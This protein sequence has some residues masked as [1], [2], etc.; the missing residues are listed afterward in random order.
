MLQQ[1]MH[2]V[3]DEIGR[4]F[5]AGIEQENAVV[6][7]LGL[8]EALCPIG[9]ASELAPS[10]ERRQDLPLVVRLVPRA[11]GDEVFQVIL[12]LG[13]RPRAALEL[14]FGKNGLRTL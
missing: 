7:E 14:R 6:K 10:D 12:E 8:G 13:H 9:P 1:E 2:A 5:M 3:A 4:R 11:A